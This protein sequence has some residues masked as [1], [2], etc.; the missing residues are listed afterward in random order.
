LL[1]RKPVRRLLNGSQGRAFD[2]ALF[3]VARVR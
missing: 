3:E 1:D 2:L